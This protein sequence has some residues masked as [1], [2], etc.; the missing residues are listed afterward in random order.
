MAQAV[1]SVA[2]GTLL[3]AVIQGILVSIGLAFV[4]VDNV[5]LWGSI[6]AV[7]AIIPGVGT[8]LITFSVMERISLNS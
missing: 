2:T 4:G 3:V 7:T 6:A 8:S 1:R 5:I